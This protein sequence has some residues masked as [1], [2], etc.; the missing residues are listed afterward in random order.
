MTP[1]S[2][3]LR[4]LLPA[5]GFVVVTGCLGVTVKLALR[6]VD[7]PVILVWAGIVYGVLAAAVVASGHASL[8][9]APGSGWAAAAATFAAAGLVF[10][11]LALKNA[12]AVV[13]V[14]VMSAYPV[15]TIAASLIVLG[16]SV[17]ATRAAGVVLVLLGV[18]LLAR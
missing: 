15:V 18:L 3:T 9:F 6:Q 11:F 14:P 4:W 1:V 10:S 7:W 12:D 2:S 16:E 17:S 5:I 13:A 8:T